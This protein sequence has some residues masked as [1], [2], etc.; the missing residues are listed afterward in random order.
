MKSI[1]PT[2]KADSVRLPYSTTV[3]RRRH[4][5]S[6]LF[7]VARGVGAVLSKAIRL[8]Q[9]PSLEPQSSSD[10]AESEQ[11][12]SSLATV[13][14]LSP[15][16]ILRD[17]AFFV[18]ASEVHF[19]STHPSLCA[20]VFGFVPG[21]VFEMSGGRA[22]ASS[23]GGESGSASSIAGEVIVVVGARGGRLWV[24]AHGAA[25][26]R[27]LPVPERGPYGTP[28]SAAQVRVAIVQHYQL[29]QLAHSPSVQRC[30]RSK[31]AR[32][33]DVQGELTWTV[34]AAY[35]SLC[36]RAHAEAQR[37]YTPD[38]LAF[39][40]CAPDVYVAA[41]KRGDSVVIFPPT[42]TPATR[43]S[44]EPPPPPTASSTVTSSI[45]TDIARRTPHAAAVVLLTPRVA[46]VT[47]AVG[48]AGEG[49]VLLTDLLTEEEGYGEASLSASVVI[50]R[51]EPDGHAHP[52]MRS[53]D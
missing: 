46:L 26:A 19:F 15:G 40:Q 22:G 43:E 21:E 32:G 49:E 17:L 6:V 27:V 12:P 53:V 8:S 25:A 23:D 45:Y 39:L 20:Q 34:C 5:S 24:W 36:A 31:A 37:L 44:A 4:S 50:R 3:H 48:W 18:Q 35:R 29:R 38:Q 30:A 2:A 51:E 1:R 9:P 28:S 14:V 42:V 10:S 47:G 7:R 52:R 13:P 11:P 41:T 33:Q 16:D